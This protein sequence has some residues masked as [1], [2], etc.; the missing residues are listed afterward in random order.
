V[1]FTAKAGDK[2]LIVLLDKVEATILGHERG[3][4][5]AVLDELNTHTLA[6]VKTLLDTFLTRCGWLGIT[7]LGSHKNTQFRGGIQ[8]N[9][10]TDVDG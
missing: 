9:V 3:D 2:D 1:T 5:L 10:A 7:A 8:Q 4:L 6:K